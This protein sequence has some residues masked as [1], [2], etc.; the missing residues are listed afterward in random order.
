[1]KHLRKASSP[2]PPQFYA[3]ALTKTVLRRPDQKPRIPIALAARSLPYL[4]RVL[5]VEA[6]G[7]RPRAWPNPLGAP[8]AFRAS[9]I[10]FYPVRIANAELLKH[11][12][13]SINSFHKEFSLL[14]G[15]PNPSM[16]T[17]S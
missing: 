2:P 5:S 7:H 3:V 15:S 8:T 12:G 13:H 16:A 14:T 6:F 9:A 17:N 1:M 11:V 10:F 4:S